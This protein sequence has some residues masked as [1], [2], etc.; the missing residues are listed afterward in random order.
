MK[1]LDSE[2]K[3]I[4]DNDESRLEQLRFSEIVKKESVLNRFKWGC[5]ETLNIISIREELL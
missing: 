3:L 4:I 5:L 2:F 1:A